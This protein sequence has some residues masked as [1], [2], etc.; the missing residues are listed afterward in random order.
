MPSSFP[1]HDNTTTH[2]TRYD[3]NVKCIST[4]I[5]SDRAYDTPY[6]V[7]NDIEHRS[8]NIDSGFGFGF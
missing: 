7:Y 4:G 5:H 8:D 1:H 2:D 3:M 6:I